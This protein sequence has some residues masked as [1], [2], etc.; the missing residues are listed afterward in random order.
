MIGHDI[1]VIGASAGGVEALTKLIKELP[2]DLPAALF[3]VL[4][5][6]EKGSSVL[7]QILNRAG[8][9]KADHFKDGEEIKYG[10][11]YVAPPGNHLLVKR[12]HICLK[13]GPRENGHRPAVDPLFRTAARAYGRRVVGV[14]LSGALDDGTAG[15]MAVKLQ[16]GVAV[17]QNP[18][19]ALFSGMPS[20]AIENV[21]VD[22]ILP[23]SE[24][25]PILVNLAYQPVEEETEKPISPEMQIE[26]DMAELEPDALHQ[27]DRPGKPSGFACPDCGGALWEISEGNLLRFRCRTG[28]AYSAKT[29][30]TQ[31]GEAL[32]EA[33]WIALRALEESSALSERLAKRARDRNHNKTA[34]QFESHAQSV[35]QRASL[36][37]E[38]LMK[39]DIQVS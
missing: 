19:E 37:R 18:E 33:L 17:V 6:P 32:E 1:I 14:V 21:D 38:V 20:T 7:P 24:I 15:L 35:L 23:V 12:G 26:S 3:V 2:S 31:Q 27:N 28:H 22:Y 10:H 4:H 39:G 16:G 34:E 30:L 25:A 5:V 9:L 36:I 13:P 29:L 8:K 11:I